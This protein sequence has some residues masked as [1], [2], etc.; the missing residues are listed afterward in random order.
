MEAPLSNPKPWP[1]Q[2][3]SYTL[4][5]VTW[6]TWRLAKKT[7]LQRATQLIELWPASKAP[8]H[9]FGLTW[10][11]LHNSYKAKCGET[12]SSFWCKSST[13]CD[14]I[15]HTP[16][17]LTKLVLFFSAKTTRLLLPTFFLYPHWRVKAQK[18]A[19]HCRCVRQHQPGSHWFV[20]MEIP[21]FLQTKQV[22]VVK[23]YV[24]YAFCIFFNDL[25][26]TLGGVVLH[27]LTL[28]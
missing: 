26:L 25:F 23:N 7:G 22:S 12:S 8:V 19:S 6:L 4:R 9:H 17:S 24:F 18:F 2:T 5:N 20:N 14:I 16:K 13:F 15:S 10:T 1:P 27:E 3:I 11:S 28:L 21:C